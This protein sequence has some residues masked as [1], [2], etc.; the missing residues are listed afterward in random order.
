VGAGAGT[1]AGAPAAASRETELEQE[2][3]LLAHTPPALAAKAAPLALP[4]PPARFS[5]ILIEYASGGELLELLR[6]PAVAARFR[7]EPAVARFYVASIALALRFLHSLRIA[8]R[9]IKVRAVRGSKV[10][11]VRG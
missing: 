1:A 3:A 9:D 10:R 11:A 7:K 2:R 6:I 4:P 5:Y 8:H